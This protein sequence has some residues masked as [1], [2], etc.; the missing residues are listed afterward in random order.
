MDRTAVGHVQS[1][2]HGAA[3]SHTW[4]CGQRA[5]VK[6]SERVGESVCGWK[7]QGGRSLRGSPMARDLTWPSGSFCGG[8]VTLRSGWPISQN[9][10]YEINCLSGAYLKC[11][12]CGI[13][14]YVL[15]G[16]LRACPYFNYLKKLGKKKKMIFP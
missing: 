8:T 11:S 6:D 15:L 7:N 2:S 13:E 12:S 3:K 10:P 1:R 9:K 16:H 5:T 4:L 14:E